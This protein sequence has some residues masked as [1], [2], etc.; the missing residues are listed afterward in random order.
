MALPESPHFLET[1]H[2]E[3][4]LVLG[5]AI[6]AFARIEW[7][8]YER[9][10][11]H[12]RDGLHEIMGELGFRQ[13]ISIMKRLVERLHPEPVTLKRITDAIGVVEKLSEKRN[14]IVHNP[15]RLWIDMESEKIMTH[16][17]KYAQPGK[18]MS[19]VELRKFAL[20]CDLAETELREALN[21]L[22]YLAG[23]Q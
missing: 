3:L 16:I 23:A 6:W 9:L 20:D 22:P 17:E 5:N 8:T 4:A 18:A 7:Q 14:L 12:S 15:W 10:R 1:L 11:L 2:T 19:L 13:R 21:S